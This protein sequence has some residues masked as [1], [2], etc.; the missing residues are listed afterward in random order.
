MGA[1]HLD[2]VPGP[3]V[4]GNFPFCRI[5][6]PDATI[7][8]SR[9]DRVNYVKTTCWE[10]ASA[11]YRWLSYRAH[12][13]G[14]LDG[15]FGQGLRAAANGGRALGDARFARQ[16]A[17]AVGRHAAKLVR[18]AQTRTGATSGGH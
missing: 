15:E 6:A 5:Y 8:I 2:D 10:V 1:R 13:N 18:A 16:I 7:C 11:A 4:G 9:S 3:L 12:A 14:E 17:D